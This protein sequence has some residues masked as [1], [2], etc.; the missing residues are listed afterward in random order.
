[1]IPASSTH[2]IQDILSYFSEVADLNLTKLYSFLGSEL[3]EQHEDLGPW[4]KNLLS[5]G[6]IVLF[7]FWKCINNFPLLSVKVMIQFP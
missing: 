2:P 7:F 1:M 3:H 6:D 4:A 5:D